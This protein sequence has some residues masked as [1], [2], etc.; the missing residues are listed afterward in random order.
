[1]SSSLAENPSI[2]SAP[3]P[4]RDR[5]RHFVFLGCGGIAAQHARRLARL[6]GVRFSFAS[7]D[8]IRAAGFRTRLGGARAYGS[9]AAAL[10]SAE[11]DTAVITTP[12]AQHLPLTLAALAAGKD[13]I[14]EKPA[15]L[16]STDVDA[17]EAAVLA[18]GRRVLVAEN[19][20][21]KP[22]AGV[23]RRIIEAGEIGEVRYLTVNALKSRRPGGWRDDAAL[24]GGGALL[25]G[26][27]HWISL[28]AG[29]GL[30]VESV[31]GYRPGGLEGIERSMLLVVQYEQGA[32][33][34]LHH[35]W[36]TPSLLRGLRI[37]R[38]YG[39][40]GSIAFESN[41]LFVLLHAKHSRVIIPGWRDIAGYHAMFTDFIACLREGREPR[42]T[43]AQA[44][45]DLELVEAA[46]RSLP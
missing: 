43:L 39:S 26:G 13:V 42:M 46:Y 16:R 8:E 10:A 23:L 41:G 1:M 7:R 27:I 34:T 24:A 44:R 28:M 37:S 4:P 21:Y 25:E 45:R 32:I 40:R 31:Q 2:P 19:Y 14:V 30:T 22:L 36:D 20:A 5:G 11:P 3:R 17:V 18:T 9:Y 15:F 29:L 33:G 12:T 6:D 35:A 38:V